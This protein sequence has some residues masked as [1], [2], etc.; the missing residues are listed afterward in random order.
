MNRQ[1]ARS[2]LLSVT[3]QCMP[4]PSHVSHVHSR[5]GAFGTEQ[6]LNDEVAR[7]TQQV[8]DLAPWCSDTGPVN[9]RPRWRIFCPVEG[10][11]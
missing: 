8:S 5:W 10:Q 1:L 2:K 7:V 6:A 11:F 9:P 4:Q 3:A